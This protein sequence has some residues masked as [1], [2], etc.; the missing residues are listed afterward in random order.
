MDSQE[1]FHL[2]NN[3]K[4]VA[5]RN[6]PG[7]I[8]VD[9]KVNLQ[10]KFYSARC[11]QC[12]KTCEIKKEAMDD[13]PNTQIKYALECKPLDNRPLKYLEIPDY[14]DLNCSHCGRSNYKITTFDAYIPGRWYTNL[15]FVLCCNYC[16]TEKEITEEDFLRKICRFG[17]VN[18]TN[19]Y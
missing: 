5:C 8:F 11:I 7:E 9:P 19:C 4:K 18:C 3:F 2:Y 17:H 15:T 14:R 6:C 1:Q 10:A 12:E 13:V 16:G